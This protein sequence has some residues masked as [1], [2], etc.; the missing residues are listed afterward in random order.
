MT[1][2]HRAVLLFAM[3]LSMFGMVELY[4]RIRNSTAVMMAKMDAMPN[5]G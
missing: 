5:K 1:I 3:P 2:L 4:L